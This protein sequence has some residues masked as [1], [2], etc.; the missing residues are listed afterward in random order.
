MEFHTQFMNVN[1]CNVIPEANLPIVVFTKNLIQHWV[2]V[3]VVGH[4]VLLSGRK[5]FYLKTPKA[6][7]SFVTT[8]NYILP[9]Y[10]TSN[11]CPKLHTREQSFIQGYLTTY[12]GTKLQILVRNRPLT[13]PSRNVNKALA[14]LGSKI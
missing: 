13:C 8:R 11:L 3:Y 5:Y 14:F 9:G 10:K 6:T 4:S 2:N 1:K 7:N 12:P